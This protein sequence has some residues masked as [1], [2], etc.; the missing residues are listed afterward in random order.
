MDRVRPY[1][2]RAV[3]A[4]A[5]LGM[6]GI[7]QA[8]SLEPP[9][10]PAAPTMKTLSEIEARTPIHQSNLPL[11]ISVDGAYYL[12]E[13]VHANQNG[14]DMITVTAN[15]VSIDLNGFTID[16][17][18]PGAVGADCIQIEQEVRTFALTNGVIRGCGQNGVLTNNPFGLTVTVDR[19]QANQSGQSGMMFG[20]GSF[21]VIS[22]SVA[23]SNAVRGIYLHEGVLT[24]CAA[25]TNGTIGLQINSGVLSGCVAKSNPGGNAFILAGGTSAATYAP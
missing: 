19:V 23:K 20:P 4:A 13:N 24:E 5:L 14:V 15:N 2:T 6:C 10:G 9:P 8:G 3:G 11:T 21:G 18:G 7:A 17:T 1:L 22:R 25:F 16:G 12:A